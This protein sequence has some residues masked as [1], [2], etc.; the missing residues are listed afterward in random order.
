MAGCGDT[1]D[2]LT[3]EG[4]SLE[5][6]RHRHATIH[7]LR[8]H[9]A[10]SLPQARSEPIEGGIRIEFGWV[11]ARRNP[12]VLDFQR[13]QERV[14]SVRVNG[15]AGEWDAVNN[16]LVVHPSALLAG[17][18]N[19][20]DIDF[21]AGDGSLNRNDEYLYTLFVPDRAHHALPL[22][23]QPD[24][25]ARV[26][27]SLELPA[28][29]KAVANG[30]STLRPEQLDG[31]FASHPEAEEDGPLRRTV[32]FEETEPIPSYLLAFAA[33]DFMTE[34]AVRAGREMTM[35]HRETDRG[36]VAR[37][38]E[39]IFD[40]HGTALEWLESYTGI[41]YPFGKFDFV[42]VPSFQYGGMEHPGSI[43]Y[44]ESS[45][46]LDE[47]ASQAQMLGRASVIAH[48][49]AHMWFGDLVTMKWFDDV[50]TKE[51]FANFMAAKI[52]HPSFPDIDHDLRFLLAH[53]PTA[54]AVDRTPGAN[55]I[56]QPLENLNEAG[57]LYGPIIYQKA[58]IVMRQL[59]LIL[60]EAGFRDGMREYL[61]A[62]RYG[63]ATWPELIE[64]LDR[65]STADLASWSRVWVEE[66]G[67]PEV[68]ARLTLDDGGRIARLT[69]HQEDPE[70][71]GRLWPQALAP[72]LGQGASAR[73][74]PVAL[75]G[76]SVEVAEAVGRAAPDYLLPD[77]SGTGYGLFRLDTTTRGALLASL[78]GVDDALARG[79]GYLA[80]FD[81]VLEREVEP[82]RFLDVLVRG[83]EGE[84]D[85]QNLT[86]ILGYL[87]TV[88]WNLLHDDARRTWAPH[89][90]ATLWN[91]ALASDSSTMIATLFN[92]YRRVATTD[93]ALARLERVWSHEE[94]VPGLPLSE[95]DE[96]DLAL[97]L[98]VSEHPGWEAILRQQADRIEN[99]ERAARF[100]FLLPSVDADPAVRE[101]FFEGLRDPAARSREP[102]VL[103]GLSYLNHP[104]R[105]AHAERFVR[106][107]L[108]LVPEIQR[109]GDIFFPG[110]WLDASLGGHNSET[111]AAI[112]RDFLEEHPDF[113]PRLRAK[114]LQSSD[115]LTRA[116]AILEG[117]SRRRELTFRSGSF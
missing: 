102:W 106:P 92:G 12:V 56:R 48:E 117:T 94:E 89:I 100:A 34:T 110:R 10:L 45:L 66:P 104:L 87:G 115:M 14:H 70:G 111:A 84:E 37:N 26:M 47:S 41:P 68:S 62:F 81:A 60:G 51:V 35:Y 67:R 49:T 59:E 91:R 99:A 72:V 80:L 28:H 53:H 38:R 15:E 97:R 113:P 107:A 86:R 52:V 93:S 114:I 39:A 19:T 32:H 112:V 29:W 85:E 96:I 31:L 5:L 2:A 43:L 116:A 63:N 108:E 40:L 50:W 13:P 69:L 82:E 17:E 7:D 27:L 61:D 21:T 18:R 33:G 109:T 44:R 1:S 30:R 90:E 83:A 64:I 24:L 58:P 3:D 57:S 74:F 36:K 95:S 25:K 65:R 77:G 42:A 73:R 101:A 105:A 75:M 6:A 23:D 22:F 78:P 103:A 88:Y 20:I 9:V 16:H 11:D 4:V 8:Y 54:Y 98:A 79:T 76:D 55:P 46:F 71:R